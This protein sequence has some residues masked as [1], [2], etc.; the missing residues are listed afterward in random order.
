[1]SNQF[2][3]L[4][5]FANNFSYFLLSHKI[6][7][8]QLLLFQSLDLQGF[9]FQNDFILNLRV[10]TFIQCML[11]TLIRP[12]IL[13]NDWESKI[14]KSPVQSQPSL[15]NISSVFSVLFRY[16]MKICRPL[17]RI[18]NTYEYKHH[19]ILFIAHLE[20]AQVIFS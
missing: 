5:K 11:R 15:S 2:L 9:L 7:N 8:S 19:I 17:T 6:L 14:P 16:P 12:V 18:W 1:M 3:L 20:F 10:Y 4:T 13:I